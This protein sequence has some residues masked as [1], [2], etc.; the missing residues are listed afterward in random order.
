MPPLARWP[1]CFGDRNL[2]QQIFQEPPPVF[3]Q[4]G[5]QRVF[6]PFG[7]QGLALLEALAK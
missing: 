4:G 3:Q 6:D 1:H 7:G 5:P 2:G